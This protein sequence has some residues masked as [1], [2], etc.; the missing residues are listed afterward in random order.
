[1]FVLR[2]FQL[3]DPD[4]GYR[5]CVALILALFGG[6]VGARV[7]LSMRS[8]RI[9][10]WNSLSLDRRS[11]PRRFWALVAFLS[12]LA[13]GTFLV[14]LASVASLILPSLAGLSRRALDVGGVLLL[15]NAVIVAL[16]WNVGRARS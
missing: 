3:T 14:L 8:G 1:M 10:V 16:L 15:L 12:M 2:S 7:S 11:S 4:A 6:V 9:G 5:A 13:L